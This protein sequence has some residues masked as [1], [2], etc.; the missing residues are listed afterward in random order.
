MDTSVDTVFAGSIPQFYDTHMVPLF[1]A[2]Y[3]A[4][5]A[6]RLAAPPL[7]GL[8]EIA[9]GTGVVTRAL[10]QALPGSVEIVATDLNPAML[11]EA[12]RIGT[13]RPVTW[14]P[15][16]VMRLPFEDASFDAVV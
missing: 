7:K 15:A 8:L 2:P 4:D 13:T 6:A 11:A 9:A 10:A 3:A 16:D 14:Q 5:L 12:A 1:F